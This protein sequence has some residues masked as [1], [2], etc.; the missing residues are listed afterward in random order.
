MSQLT[1]ANAGVGDAGRSSSRGRRRCC[2]A[3][4]RPPAAPKSCGVQRPISER[5][6]SSASRVSEVEAGADPAGRCRACR[7]RADGAGG[8]SASAFDRSVDQ[9]GRPCSRTLFTS[10]ETGC[11]VRREFGRR[12]QQSVQVDEVVVVRVQPGIPG[13]GG[14]I[15]G[16]RSWIGAIV[17]FAVVVMTVQLCSQGASGPAVLVPPRLPEPGDGERLPVEAMDEV[18]LLALA[19][20]GPPS[21]TR[22]SPP[23]ARCSACLERALEGGFVDQRFGSGVDHL[24]AD[25]GVLRPR[26]DEA[27]VEDLD[28]AHAIRPLHHGVDVVGRGDVEARLRARPPTMPSAPKYAAIWSGG[29]AETNRPHMGHDPRQGPGHL[30]AK[31]HC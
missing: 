16:I 4:L 10:V 17:S 14:R 11:I 18:R 2:G 3:Q 8:R 26:R 27:P 1:F 23:S 28:T 21:A 31:L 6:L 19:V 13:R 25:L 15:T 29:D 20:T 30:E 12:H 5:G 7:F 9:F 22:R 24:R